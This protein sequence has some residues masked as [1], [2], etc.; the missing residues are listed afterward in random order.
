[1]GK[2]VALHQPN[3]FQSAQTHAHFSATSVAGVVYTVT[4]TLTHL[5]PL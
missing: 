4:L 3:L 2:D 5:N 1:M